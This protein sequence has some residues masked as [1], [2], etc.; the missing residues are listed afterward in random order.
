MIQMST[1]QQVQTVQ[2]QSFGTELPPKKKEKEKKEKASKEKK[3]TST[4]KKGES[5]TA[6]EQE[7]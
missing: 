5:E 3:T 6:R 4:G 2:Q 7:Y 1:S